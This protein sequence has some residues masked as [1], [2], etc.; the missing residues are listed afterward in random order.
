MWKNSYYNS[1]IRCILIIILRI[2]IIISESEKGMRTKK[3]NNNR[4]HIEQNRDDELKI[5]LQSYQIADEQLQM[6]VQ[7]RD[8]FAIQLM[9]AIGALLGIVATADEIIIKQICISII[10]ILCTY[11]CGQIFSSYEVHHRLVYYIKN[12]LEENISKRLSK[13]V[14][15]W[16]SFCDYDRNVIIKSKIGGRESFFRNINIIVPIVSLIV[17]SAIVIKFEQYVFYHNVILLTLN[18]LIIII[19]E[20]LAVIWAFVINKRYN[21]RK[22]E[23]FMKDHIA[24]CG[25]INKERLNLSQK[26]RAVFLDR[27]G[28][29]I[30]D[31]VETRKIEDLEFFNDIQSL[32]RLSD[33]NFLLIIVTNQSGIGKGNYSVKEMTDFNDYMISRLKELGI[34]IDALYYCPHKT[35]DNCQCKKPKDGMLRRAAIELNVDLS[36]SYIIGDQNTD[37]MAGINAGLKEGIA[38]PTGLY[39]KNASKKYK[40]DPLIADETIVCQSL[41]DAVDEVLK[42]EFYVNDD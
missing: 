9:L 40:K 20:I 4:I 5:L 19:I 37:I 26:N 15:M 7:Q 24:K 34:V 32:K 14:L 10:P 16:E 42:K 38:V 18:S 8:N 3:N 31:K 41:K 22:Y 29:I 30:I 27:D 12:V 17:N 35:E 36:Q 23:E 33:A 28:T 39:P 1:I 6:R 25:F 13:D 21:K 2:Y 11:F